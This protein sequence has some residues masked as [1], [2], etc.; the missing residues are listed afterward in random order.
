MKPNML[1]LLDLS[2][3]HLSPQTREKLEDPDF[4]DKCMVTDRDH[5]YFVPATPAIMS[6]VD[7]VPRDL[8][9]CLRFATANKADY[10]IFDADGPQQDELPWYEDN[11]DPDLTGTGITPEMMHRD[12]HGS[13][14]DPDK[15]DFDGLKVE[16]TW[17]EVLE[18]GDYEAP[19]GAWVGIGPASLRL[20]QD[21][22]GDVIVT[23]FVRGMENRDPVQTM[24]MALE[25]FS[26]GID[27]PLI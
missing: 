11:P 8:L 19:E 9:H 14:P 1:A 15:V 21:K 25:W 20:R 4:R 22:A 5:G 27:D 2:T 26:E 23:A 24:D 7:V 12:E 13:Y 18:D 3:G 17:T 10:I 16:R 6:I